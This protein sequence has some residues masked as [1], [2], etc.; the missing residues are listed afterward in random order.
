[1]LGVVK[2]IINNNLWIRK[3]DRNIVIY[4]RSSGFNSI[5]CER[6][7]NVLNKI[8]FIFCEE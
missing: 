4:W 8:F 7:V 6:Y 3:F 2:N 5:V 1:M